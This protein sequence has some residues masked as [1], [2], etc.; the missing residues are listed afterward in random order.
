MYVLVDVLVGVFTFNGC[1]LSEARSLLRVRWGLFL[2]RRH[3]LEA[4]RS[5]WLI[6]LGLVNNGYLFM[7][8]MF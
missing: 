6:F 3:G 4:P 1:F 2:D 7:Q 5:I 8:N